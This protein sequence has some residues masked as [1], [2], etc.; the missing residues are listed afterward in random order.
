VPLFESRERFNQDNMWKK[1]FLAEE[2]IDKIKF[3]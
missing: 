2:I 3:S 1:A